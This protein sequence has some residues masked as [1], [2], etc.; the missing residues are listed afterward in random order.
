MLILIL[1]PI[2]LAL[3][4]SVLLFEDINTSFTAPHYDL[5]P[6]IITL[7]PENRQKRVA[8]LFEALNENIEVSEQNYSESM[9]DIYETYINYDSTPEELAPLFEQLNTSWQTNQS[10]RLM[11]REQLKQNLNAQEWQMFFSEIS[12]EAQ[13]LQ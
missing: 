10:E 1:T 13:G 12:N 8:G 2:V 4:T 3:L 7:T 5:Q 6:K 11:I 9:T